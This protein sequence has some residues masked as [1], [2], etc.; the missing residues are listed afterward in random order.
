MASCDTNQLG[1][2]SADVL[3]KIFSTPAVE[4]E[5]FT[6]DDV[7]AREKQAREVG[8]RE[9]ENR[10]RANFNQALMAERA[11]IQAAIAKFQQERESYYQRAEGEII[12]LALAIARKILHREAQV[13]PLLL[14]GVARVALERIAT[15]STVRLRVPPAEVGQWQEALAALENL[16][17]RPEV[18]G[19]ATLSTAQL[20]L[21]TEVGTADLSLEGQLKEI[22]QGFLD[23]LALRP[24]RS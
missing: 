23:L 8:F 9:G 21:E 22:E 17:P 1:G 14:A 4:H 20:I 2:C 13:D 3:W 11:K 12:R 24:E 7:Q 16:H 10:A 15:A 18:V 5:R 19:D 6:E